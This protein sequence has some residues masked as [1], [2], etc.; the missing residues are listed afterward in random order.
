VIYLIIAPMDPYSPAITEL[1]ADSVIDA[2]SR[3]VQGETRLT[4]L[5]SRVL[6]VKEMVKT[7]VDGCLWWEEPEHGIVHHVSI[8]TWEIVGSSVGLLRLGDRSW[9]SCVFKIRDDRTNDR[10]DIQAG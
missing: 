9:G 10:I 4:Y 5:T 3:W 7:Q 1:G 6:G 2:A 8:D